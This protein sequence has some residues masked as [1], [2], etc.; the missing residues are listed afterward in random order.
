MRWLYI[1][2]LIKYF[3]YKKKHFDAWLYLFNT[4]LDEMFEGTKTTLAKKRA[5]GIA[6]VMLLKMSAENI[7]NES[8]TAES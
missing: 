3:H 1:L 8:H 4:T 2:I 7:S 5:E 6:Q